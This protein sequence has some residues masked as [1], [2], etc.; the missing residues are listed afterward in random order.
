[1][2]PKKRKQQVFQF[3]TVLMLRALPLSLNNPVAAQVTYGFGCLAW[4][5]SRKATYA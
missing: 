2:S 5:H 1:M 4:E 3:F